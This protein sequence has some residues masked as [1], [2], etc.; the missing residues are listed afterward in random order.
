MSLFVCLFVCLSVIFQ[1]FELLTQLKISKFNQ[2]TVGAECVFGGRCGTHNCK[3]VR[4]VI[5]KSGGISW[6]NEQ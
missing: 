5:D 2:L 1:I 6:A 4:S 3:L